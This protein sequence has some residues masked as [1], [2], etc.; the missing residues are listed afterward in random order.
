MVPVHW[1]TVAFFW[2]FLLFPFTFRD[3]LSFTVYN[4]R[5]VDVLYDGID[6]MNELMR[7]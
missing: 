2:L 6:Y 1:V 7:L 4:M 3:H 5:L